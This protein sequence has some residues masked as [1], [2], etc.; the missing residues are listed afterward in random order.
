MQWFKHHN[1]FRNSPA[2]LAIA[3]SLGERG[4]AAAYRLLE[5]MCEQCGAGDNYNPVLTLAPPRDALWL[6]REIFIPN[7]EEPYDNGISKKETFDALEGFA[8]ASLISL[9][10]ELC[11]RSVKDGSGKWIP[12]KISFPAIRLLG[13]EEKLDEWTERRR[14]AVSKAMA[15]SGKTKVTLGTRK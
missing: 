11:D 13:F 10:E 2:M 14:R 9:S 4:V 8:C 5:V 7:P 3:D 1:N 12:T 15:K 6:G